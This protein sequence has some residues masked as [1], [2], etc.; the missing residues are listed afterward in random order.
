MEENETKW[1]PS[2]A[3]RNNEDFVHNAIEREAKLSDQSNKKQ[4]KTIQGKAK[5]VQ[6]LRFVCVVDGWRELNRREK[7]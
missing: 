1:V 3:V 7:E 4:C 6:Q 5:G 2:V